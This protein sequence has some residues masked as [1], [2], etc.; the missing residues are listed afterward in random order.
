ME[1]GYYNAIA[2]LTLQY[3]PIDNAFVLSM[4]FTVPVYASCCN[5][6]NDFS[7]FLQDRVTTVLSEVEN[8]TMDCAHKIIGN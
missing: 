2:M 4:R 8:N 7:I 3:R 1:L 5:C 6:E